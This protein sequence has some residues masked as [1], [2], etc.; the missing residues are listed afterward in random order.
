[1]TFGSLATLPPDGVRYKPFRA[2]VV[3]LARYGLCGILFFDEKRAGE[4][5]L[6]ALIC[7]KQNYDV[8]DASIIMRLTSI[9]I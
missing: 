3:A 8:E 4:F 9:D 6:G 7:L 2:M 5:P 1:L